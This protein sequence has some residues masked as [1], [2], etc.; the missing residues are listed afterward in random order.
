MTEL[1]LSSE[2]MARMEATYAEMADAY[3]L[4]AAEL[5]FS[6]DGCADNCCDSYFL[7]HTYV[8]WAYLW[9]G[10]SELEAG[11]QAD[12]LGRCRDY[13]AGCQMAEARQERPQLMCPLNREGLCVLYKHRLLVCR[14]HGV[15]AVMRFPNG[16]IRHFLGCFRCQEIV[17]SRFAGTE[18]A[19]HVERTP[20]LSQLLQ[21]ENE[22]CLYKRASLPKVKKTIAEML[23][24]GAPSY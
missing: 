12:I 24:A 23:L 17:T 15:P 20:H 21:L 3:S 4:V 22:L 9:Q 11:A 10:F 13:V 14:T 7:H 8:E 16:Q 6:C 5:G 1:L 2:Q 18:S 19:P